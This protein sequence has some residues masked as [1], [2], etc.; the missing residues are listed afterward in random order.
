MRRRMMGVLAGGGVMCVGIGAWGQQAGTRSAA[1]DGVGTMPSGGPIGRLAIPGKLPFTISK[2][3]TAITGPLRAD[4]TVDYVA[5]LNEEYGKGVTPENNGF[6]V[7]LQV[8][9][10]GDDVIP[11]K[12]KA[13]FLKLCGARETPAGAQVWV[14][15]ADYLKKAKGLDGD[16][17]SAAADELSDTWLASWKAG[18]HPDVA[19]YLKKQ[20]S[21]MAIVAQ[22]AG[23]PK[24]WSPSV[25]SDGRTLVS[26]LLLSLGLFRDV[27]NALCAR[28]TL[29]AGSGDMDG[30]LADI[31]TLRKFA[32]LVGSGQT[33]I[34]RLVGAALETR[35]V[36][37]VAGVAGTGGLTEAQ[38]KSVL[39]ALDGFATMPGAV[40]GVD[41]A[42][43]W[44]NLDMVAVIASGR[45]HLLA[46]ISTDAGGGL[47]MDQL[48]GTINTGAVDWDQVLKQVNGF[49]DEEVRCDAQ[50]DSFTE[51][52]AKEWRLSINV[53][54]DGRRRSE[55]SKAE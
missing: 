34:E 45:T 20:E 27:G 13:A 5:A 14:S 31:G 22:A 53:W 9:G 35:A 7:W 36:E 23:R 21:L 39:A 24:W 48:L 1:G 50:R 32:R 42:E 51:M 26:V 12:I 49:I 38:C 15:Y 55:R 11:E 54:R 4:G 6:V 37:A 40:E 3:T 41:I 25:A 17:L 28:A 33:L 18:A 44:D 43:R 30:F 52:H 10:T 2:E 46:P 47:K 16:A 19:A 8:E 29:R